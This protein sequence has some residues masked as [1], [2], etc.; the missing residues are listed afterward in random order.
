MEN[1]VFYYYRMEDEFCYVNGLDKEIVK[2]YLLYAITNAM[3]MRIYDN[4]KNRL[5]KLEKICEYFDL[6]Y[7]EM[8]QEAYYHKD[9]MKYKAK[10]ERQNKTPSI[11][12][13]TSDKGG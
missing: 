8:Y 4:V 6:D 5:E 1:G 9:T 10:K 7:D 12:S 2:M 13:K 3:N 11:H